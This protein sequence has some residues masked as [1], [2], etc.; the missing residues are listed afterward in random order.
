MEYRVVDVFA[1]RPLEGNPLTVVPN[2]AGLSDERMQAIARETNHSE[3][4]FVTGHAPDGTPQ[5]RIFTPQT[6]LP[7]AGHPTL[8]TAWVTDADA[9]DLSIGR[10]PIEREGDVLWM[11]QNPATFEPLDGPMLE[12][13]LG[14]PVVDAV[15]GSTGTPMGLIEVADSN[16]VRAATCNAGAYTGPSIACA[17]VFATDSDHDVHARSFGPFVGV[18]EDPA[19]GSAAGPLAGWLASRGELNRER[20]VHQGIEMKRPSRLHIAGTAEA[21]RVGGRVQPV[22]SGWFTLE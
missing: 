5:V 10:I 3:T 22:A 14:V 15:V 11:T 2:A 12:A 19:T 21:P 6:E 1:E 13:C 17:Y 20:V 7:F 8:G 9:L 18:P 4:T 16:A